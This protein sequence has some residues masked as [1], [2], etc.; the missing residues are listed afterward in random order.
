[1][2]AL[3]PNQRSAAFGSHG[4]CLGAS[5]RRKSPPGGKAAFGHSLFHF[6]SP[7]AQ[8]AVA[9]KVSARMKTLTRYVLVELLKVFAVT[10]AGMTLF[11]MLVGVMREAYSQ[12]LG[13]KQIALLMPYFL[14]E[15]LRFAV[16]G[17]ILFA[18][19]SIYGRLAAAN[20]VI[21]VK[22]L[23]I[24]PMVLFWPA[25]AFAAALS[26]GTVW[27]NDVAVSW[28]RHGIRR[29]VIESVEEVAYAKLAQQ[30]SFATKNFAINV[31]AVEGRKLV[32]PTFTFQPRSADEPGFTV[33]AE[34]AELRTDNEYDTLTVVFRDAEVEGQSFSGRIPDYEYELPLSEATRKGGAGDSTS[35]LPMS[36]I[37]LDIVRQ[38][39]NILRWNREMAA[40]AAFSMI[41]G[42]FRS[43]NETAWRPLVKRVS[44]AENRIARLHME[45]HRRWANGFSCLCFVM[46]G[47]P[48]AIVLRNSDF[49]TS[50]FICFLPILILYYPLLMFSV[51]RAKSGGIPAFS[52][53][54]GNAIMV[55]WGSWLLRR[56]VRY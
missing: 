11:V 9:A 20:E 17:T 2:A 10:L 14:P 48:L 43:L 25:F 45:P 55:A 7:F 40:E 35:N 33:T 46:V 1:L 26:I 27:L 47:A 44:D 54:L 19:C 6:L 21:A 32:R 31:K 18:A 38:E 50:F 5:K 53:W 41:S 37:P 56:V 30:K 39:Q 49:L 52:V 16:P 12:G 15:A 23:G 3:Q 22:S 36:E 29:I 4:G 24:S 51:E 8:R 42:D 34:M 13:L 28:G